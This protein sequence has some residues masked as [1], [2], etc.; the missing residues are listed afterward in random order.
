MFNRPSQKNEF[1]GRSRRNDGIDT[2]GWDNLTKNV[3]SSVGQEHNIEEEHKNNQRNIITRVLLYGD[4]PVLRQRGP[5]KVRPGDMDTLIKKIADGSVTVDDERMLLGRIASPVDRSSVGD[6]A[7]TIVKNSHE[8]K[9]LSYVSSLDLGRFDS[10]YVSSFMDK[11]PTPIDF[12]KTKASF[13]NSIKINNSR[14][15][16]QEY[17]R[18]MDQF[19]KDIYG[20]RQ[21]YY[22]RLQELNAAAGKY[23]KNRMSGGRVLRSFE[24]E[25]Q[26]ENPFSDTG[27]LVVS[28][29]LLSGEVN[30][31]PSEDSIYIDENGVM[32]VFDGVGGFEGGEVASSICRDSLE[33]L[34]NE[35]DFKTP[36]GREKLI[37]SLNKK[38]PSTSATTC[39]I[40]KTEKNPDGSFTLY[41][42][43]VGD[44]RLYI[45]RGDNAYQ[46]T[47][48]D[49]VT[50]EALDQNGVTDPVRRK[51]LL[52]HGISNSFGG[53]NFHGSLPGNSGYVLLRRGDKIVLCSDGVSGDIKG[54]DLDQDDIARGLKPDALSEAEIA[55]IVNSATACSEAASGLINY[56]KKYDDRSALVAA[57]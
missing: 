21:E 27:S 48:D 8:R 24:S 18:D 11:F 44:S 29:S 10:S 14:E 25:K 57:L 37:A 5:I 55:K 40:T 19:C 38:V 49:S 30:G 47:K 39:V 35:V 6:V 46:I 33:G 31:K 34:L 22:E 54:S 16:Y 12:E 52:L 20:K 7:S 2:D 56:A 50:K 43:S 28:K 15:K 9:I 42:V 36:N 53:G 4:Y 13:L 41:Y 1:S 3:D 23:L 32:A 51:N 45:V 17:V 26:N